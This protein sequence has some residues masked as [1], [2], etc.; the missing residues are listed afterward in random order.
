VTV[1]VDKTHYAPQDTI[2]VTISNGLA[3][4]ISTTDHQTNC[5]IVTLERLANGAWQ[6]EGV[7]RLKTPTRIVPI[8]PGMTVQQLSSSPWPTG[9][10]RVAFR[11]FT[12]PDAVQGASPGQGGLVYSTTFTI[13]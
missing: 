4:T 11:Y 8:S 12:E 13:G 2:T 9:T 3:T 5:T 10:Y 6:A 1:T 7:C